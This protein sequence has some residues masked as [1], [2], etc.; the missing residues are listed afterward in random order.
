[1]PGNHPHILKLCSDEHAPQVC[2]YA[3]DPWVRTPNLDR[4]AAEGT[5]FENCYVANP[6]CLPGRLSMLSGK[7]PRELGTPLYGDLLPPDTPTYMGHFA[8]HG[9]QTTCVGKMHFTGP[10]QMHGWMFRPYGDM[11]II[12]HQRVPGYSVNRD[13]MRNLP[14]PE[15]HGGGL[16]H[17]VRTAGPGERG[18]TLF[19]DSVTREARLHLRDY[20][21][22]QLIPVY[23]GERPLLFEVSWKTPHWS[24][25]APPDLYEYYREIVDLPRKPLPEAA[26]PALDVGDFAVCGSYEKV[27]RPLV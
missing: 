6:I 1:M 4:L 12:R 26:P 17:W 19:D 9:Y 20:F 25:I 21:D 27:R 18:F 7:L 23:H 8:G 11:E 10:E 16:A 22:W 3:G 24:F 13:V 2:G 15:P 5:V 14:Q